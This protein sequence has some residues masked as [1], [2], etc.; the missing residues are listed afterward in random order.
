M[1]DNFKIEIV[2]GELSAQD[3][4]VMI[5]G[6]LAYHANNGHPRETMTYSVLLRNQKNEVRGAIVVSFLYNGMHIDLLWVDES[7]RNQDWGS[8]LIKIAEEE[9]VRRGCALAYTDTFTWQAPEFYKKNGYTIYG[10]LDDF[11]VGN[12]L[13]YF[14]KKLKRNYM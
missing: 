2:N 12:S 9:A 13:Y 14:V 4:N 10:E 1:N 7:L 6:M 11:P 8:K 3:K 5:E